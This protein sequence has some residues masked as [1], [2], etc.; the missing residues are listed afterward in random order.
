M[1][2][3]G[4]VRVRVGTVVLCVL[5]MTASLTGGAIAMRLSEWGP[6]VNVASIPGTSPELNTEALEGCPIESPDGLSLYI[7][8]DRDGGLGGLDIWVAHR[9]TV[10]APWGAPV[11]LGAPIN[12][13]ADDFCPTPVRGRGLFFVSTRA[14]G[15]GAADIYFARHNPR[16]GW[17]APEHLPCVEDGGPNSAASA[18]GPSY[19]EVDGREFLYFSA[20][21]NLYVSERHAG[22]WG[23]AVPVT[24]LNT[25]HSDLRPN[26]RKDGLEVV[27]DSNRPGGFGSFDIYTAT[28]L[29]VDDPWSTPINLGPNI[30]TE[31]AET[32]PSFSWDGRRLL[33]GS[34]RPGG[35]GSS[36][37]YLSTRDR[38][39]GRPH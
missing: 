22:S 12:S 7:A 33:F 19:F 35:A 15:C 30:N 28:R 2:P 3:K 38:L 32:R 10:A 29:S 31:H 9:E 18:A 5:S 39:T 26:V 24:E 8:S 36:D 1:S 25:D 27:F 16:H 17:G 20:G 21:P 6:A 4:R 37:V 13:D 14:G 23:P 11:N 34:N